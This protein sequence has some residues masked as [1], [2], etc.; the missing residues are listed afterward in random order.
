MVGAWSR[1]NKVPS[2]AQ[3]LLAVTLLVGLG[4]SVSLAQSSEPIFIGV[5][6]TLS[7]PFSNFGKDDQIAFTMALD[8]VNKAGGIRGRPLKFNFVDG[9]AKTDLTR[10]IVQK[11]IDV[12]K[13]IMILGGDTSA[14]CTIIA[15]QVQQAKVP[16]LMHVCLADNLTQQGWN[17]VFRIPPP[18]SYGIGGLND[19]LAKVVRPQ[20]V[21]LVFESS[22][23]GTLIDRVLKAWAQANGV[24]FNS[25]SFEPGGLDYRPLLTKVKLAN[26]NVIMFGCY[27]ADAIT[28]TKQSAELGLKPKVFVGAAGHLYQEWVSAVGNL[29]ENY[30]IPTQGYMDV[31]YPG[32][33]EFWDRYKKTS[34]KAATFSQAS[35][36]ASVQVL[37]DVLTRVNLTGNVAMDRNAIRDALAATDLNTVFGPVK[38]E[39]FDGFTNQT[40]LPALLLQVQ[41]TTGGELAWHT[42]WPEAV[43]SNKY[44]FPVPGLQQ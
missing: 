32:A 22:V 20:S 37:K 16:Y 14:T 1:K 44:I 3:V 2:L 23:Y 8:D 12:D 18:L 17:Y 42:V 9:Q 21:Y 34:G 40:K 41:K 4:C 7:G 5:P 38:F 35:A 10:S 28:L 33:A 29:A 27:L 15:Q 26:P 39:A 43:A 24:T 25:S 31:K 13:N 11:M 36:Y 30:F 19:F 6:Q